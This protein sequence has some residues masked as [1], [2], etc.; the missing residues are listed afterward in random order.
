[1]N[2]SNF[3]LFRNVGCTM[4]IAGLV[5]SSYIVFSSIHLAWQR[6]DL[7]STSKSWSV[8]YFILFYVLV[9][10]SRS[11][12]IMCTDFDLISPIILAYMHPLS[13]Y[14]NNGYV[15]VSL[16]TYFG[17]LAEFKWSWI[18]LLICHQHLFT[19]C[20]VSFEPY[21]A[22]YCFTILPWEGYVSWH[23]R[24]NKLYALCYSSAIIFFHDLTF[25]KITWWIYGNS[26]TPELERRV[27]KHERIW[28]T[29][30][31]HSWYEW[32]QP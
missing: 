28:A 11:Y 25:S 6:N 31:L 21:T 3:V 8:F 4:V 26:V 1:M 17:H 19:N 12:W 9:F 5:C 2:L 23:Y 10:Y 32:N 27:E 15:S 22:I 13:N 18:T 14:I 30:I 29:R 20:V 24:D 7:Q 16:W